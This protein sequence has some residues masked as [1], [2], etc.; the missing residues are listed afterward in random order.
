MDSDPRPR[1]SGLRTTLGEVSTS[2]R[3]V[4]DVLGVRDLRRA[5]IGFTGFAITEWASF[6]AIMVY[7]YQRGGTTEVAIISI[8]QLG[9]AAAFAPFA[10]T[11]G[12]R[13]RRELMLAVS[14]GVMALCTGATAAVLLLDAPAPVVYLFSV[15][16]AMSITL[17][18]PLHAPFLPALARSPQELTAAYVADGVV[19]SSSAMFGPA[20]AGAMMAIAG[21][22]AVYAACSA[23][24]LLSLVVVLRIAVRT[25]PA[26]PSDQ[27][28]GALRE[29]VE[30]FAVLRRDSRPRVIVALSA[31]GLVVLGLV[32]VLA[33]VLAFD[34]FGSGESGAGFLNAALGAGAMVGS[35]A[36]VRMI[37]RP[38]LYGTVRNSMLLYGLPVAAAAAIPNQA[39]AAAALVASGSG[40][41]TLDV[42]ART[43]LQ[44]VVPE[45]SQSRVFGVLEGAFMAG[46]G[47]GSVLAA[48]FVGAF[49]TRGAL[50]ASGLLLPVLGLATR[51]WLL[52]ADVGSRVPAEDLALLHSLPLFAGLAAPDLERIGQHAF[53][54]SFPAGS[55]VIR[56]GDPGDRFY[57]IR[58]GRV[59]VTKESRHLA[60]LEE[61]AYFGEIALLRD[62]PRTATVAAITGLDALVLD[63]EHF[64][65][66]VT[67]HASGSD[68]ADAV[69]EERLRAHGGPGQPP[70][71][72]RDAGPAAP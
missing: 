17:I 57:V 53:R 52:D 6:V 41:S 32:E 27:A 37:A 48:V 54:L 30:G 31:T 19:E 55:T 38:R 20:L 13:Y 71:T 10:A 3:V 70:A 50:I 66:A 9:P 60:S 14:Y 68:A 44:R 56:E 22:G 23:L 4:R 29:V 72:G 65:D 45:A 64:L 39:F 7:A 33:V 40:Y 46:E 62:V 47:V 36:A 28:L 69:V 35:F 42:A 25:K 43:M 21:P 67:M 59:E 63:R 16:T 49:G 8:L 34:S 61:G 24:L 1:T 58:S 2:L 26:A 5:L 51:K 18:R 15:L 12:D 11:L